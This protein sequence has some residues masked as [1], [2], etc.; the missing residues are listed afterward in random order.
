MIYQLAVMLKDTYA[1]ILGCK[2]GR[3]LKVGDVI[4]DYIRVRV[5]Y[6]LEEPLKTHTDI[7]AK[8]K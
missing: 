2:L 1:R 4:E 3:V 8:G 7:K 6:P 5:A